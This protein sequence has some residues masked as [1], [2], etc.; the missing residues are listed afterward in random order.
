MGRALVPGFPSSLDWLNATPPSGVALRGWLTVVAFVNIGSSWSTQ[1]LHDLQALRARYPG[2]FRVFAIHVPRFDH[3]RDPRRVMKRAHRHGVRFPIALDSD[4]VAWQQW[5]VRHWPSM[6]LIDGAGEIVTRLEGG[7]AIA[8]FEKRL[9]ALADQPEMEDDGI[10]VHR[11]REP[12]MPLQF[13]TGLAVTSQYLYIAD[14]GHHRVLE[15]NHAGRILRTFGTG[16]ATLNDGDAAHAS[17]HSPCGLTLQR[18]MLYVADSGN[19]AVRRINLR[20][21]DTITLIG[22][23]RR[24]TPTEGPVRDTLAVSLDTPRAVAVAND[25]L[26]VALAGDNTVWT[27]ELGNAQL[28][29]RA[30]SGA[31]NV[32]DG[33]GKTAAFAQPVALAA[34][35]QTLYVCDAA[36]SA[37]R[38]LQLR[39]QAVQTL[40]GQGAWTFG[41]VDGPRNIAQ[42]QEPQAI[43]LDPDAPLLWIADAGNDRLRSLRLGGGDLATHML[44]QP[45]HG[46]AG[47]AVGAGSVW[48]A[49]TDAHAIL[50]VDPKTGAVQHVPVGE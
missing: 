33:V 6:V 46:P 45:L 30:G 1:A 35:Q 15:C 41:H 3:E 26:H 17:F 12:E 34:V 38:S 9:Q 44:P 11:G 43:A 14:T 29:F 48:I 25:Q 10:V 23:G 27:Y 24:G 32:K 42:L 37:I 40:L 13:P 22:N 8:V 16:A 31:L 39:D 49:D 7:D 36:G 19:H 50:R 28:T 20:T 21:G 2:K 18:D 47:L 5:G 4:W